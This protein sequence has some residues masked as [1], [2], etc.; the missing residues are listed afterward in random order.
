MTKLSH[1]ALYSSKTNS[2][3]SQSDICTHKWQRYA[4]ELPVFASRIRTPIRIHIHFSYAYLLQVSGIGGG[5]WG[6]GTHV[7]LHSKQI[8]SRHTGT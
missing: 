8:N 4:S 3:P 7:R 5:R 6:R 2:G 1:F